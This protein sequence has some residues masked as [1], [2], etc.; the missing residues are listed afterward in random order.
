M[1]TYTLSIGSNSPDRFS[2][3]NRAMEWLRSEFC[4]VTASEV[5]SSRPVSGVGDDYCNMVARVSSELP[6]AEVIAKAKRFEVECG[7]TP[8]S[9]QLGSVPMDVDVVQCDALIIRPAEFTREYFMRGYR[10]LQALCLQ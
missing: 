4:D 3:M 8:Q 7:R 5:Y 9:K 2:Q 10:Q 6:P 1:S